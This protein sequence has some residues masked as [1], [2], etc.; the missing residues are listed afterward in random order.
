M[1]CGIGLWPNI[2]IALERPPTRRSSLVGITSRYCW[3]EHA[4]ATTYKYELAELEQVD[5]PAAAR[6]D[7][8]SAAIRTRP[9]AGMIG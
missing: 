7:A 6:S 1:K 3:Q 2:L 4:S 9:E 8:G 5:R